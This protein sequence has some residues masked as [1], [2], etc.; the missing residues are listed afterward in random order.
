MEIKTVEENI[1]LLLV[2]PSLDE[3]SSPD[4][5]TRPSLSVKVESLHNFWSSCILAVLSCID[6]FVNMFPESVYNIN[7]DVHFGDLDHSGAY[8]AEILMS[9][10]E[11]I[12]VLLLNLMG[13]CKESKVV[14]FLEFFSVHTILK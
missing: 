4:F 9:L 8:L 11:R 10:L 6:E 3:T 2:C 13:S 7:I 12:C 14:F 5:R 1:L